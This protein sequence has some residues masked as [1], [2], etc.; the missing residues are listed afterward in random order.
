MQRA[1]VGS[2]MAQEV[3]AGGA[4]AHGERLAA[5]LSL[6]LSDEFRRRGVRAAVLN[7][8][9]GI[10][11]AVA[12]ALCVRALGRDS[13]FTLAVPIHSAPDDREDALLVARTLGV[14]IRVVDLTAVYD[15]MV[16][17]LGPEIAG[18]RLASANIRPRL[19]MTALYAEAAVRGAL[20]VGT[21][22]RDEL[23]VGY[24]TKYG[25][26]GVDLLPLGSC[27]KGEVWELGR[28]LGIPQRVIDRVPTAGLWQG[29]TDEGELG[30]T[31]ADLDRYLLTGEATDA[32]RDR[33]EA[34]G[35][36]ARHKL[37]MPPLAPPLPALR[38]TAGPGIR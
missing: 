3:E 5:H 8:S 9:G 20:V 1:E 30:F 37:E 36:A 15:A 11:S 35:R 31:Y 2:A 13:V 32:L 29:Q 34:L 25:D 4:R 27:T 12:C 18:H 24:F 21:G 10:D 7:L 33:V 16:A 26:G 14:A 19:R 23:A 38:R 6:W 28:V 17:A 22:N